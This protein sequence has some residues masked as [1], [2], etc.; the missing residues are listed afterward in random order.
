MAGLRESD[1]TKRRQ[2]RG[3]S[4]QPCKEQSRTAGTNWHFPWL[5][6][7]CGG[8]NGAWAGSWCLEVIPSTESPARRSCSQGRKAQVGKFGVSG[9]VPT[10]RA[11]GG[12]PKETAGPRAHPWSPWL[13]R[14][15]WSSPWLPTLGTHSRR[16]KGL[17]KA[18]CRG[19]IASCRAGVKSK[20]VTPG[21]R[22]GKSRKLLHNRTP[23][24]ME[25]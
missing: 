6:M 23:L 5:Q 16:G 11:H 21:T 3:P 4:S 12:E 17:R 9:C 8:D 2:E 20:A 1:A 19:S 7:K 13:A 14:S 10:S 15:S 24:G 18:L 22:T 25:G